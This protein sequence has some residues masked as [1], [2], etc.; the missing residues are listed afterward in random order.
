M[1]VVRLLCVGVGLLICLLPS[2]LGNMARAAGIDPFRATEPS[3]LTFQSNTTGS[4]QPTAEGYQV[5]LPA[6]PVSGVGQ[7]SPWQ[8]QATG[9]ITGTASCDSTGMHGLIT[10]EGGRPLAGTR[11]GVW[12]ADP[13]GDSFLSQPTESDGRWEIMLDQEGPLAGR[14]LVAVVDDSG[15]PVSP[16]VGTVAYQDLPSQVQA[17]GIPTHEDCVNGHQW[18]T[19]NFRARSEYPEYV[20]ASTRFLSCSENHRD[21]NIRL[22]VIEQDGTGIKGVAVRF[23][24]VGGFSDDVLT[25]RDIFK[26][27]GYVDYPIFARQTWMTSVLAGTSDVSPLMSSEAPPVVDSC[28][29]NEWGHYSY[30]VVYQRR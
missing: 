4:L 12:A 21:H 24:E 11:V 16:V 23:Q 30:E 25:G 18:L 29:G 6:V 10:D 15:L 8:Y 5:F 19:V 17:A 14:W 22:W 20:L 7:A 27:Q 28:P 2:N 13:A 3:A 9:V 26:P 1:Q